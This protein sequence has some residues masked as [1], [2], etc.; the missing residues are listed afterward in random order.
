VVECGPLDEWQRRPDEVSARRHA[1]R[2]TSTAF[3]EAGPT[4]QRVAEVLATGLANLI[5]GGCVIRGRKEQ[6]GGPSLACAHALAGSLEALCR[7]FETSPYALA[8]ACCAQAT[9]TRR[10]ILIPVVSSRVMRLWTQ[11]SGWQYLDECQMGSLL[12]APVCSSHAVRATILVWR[13]QPCRPLTDTHTALLDH[14]ARRLGASSQATRCAALADPT[15][16]PLLLGP[17]Q[18]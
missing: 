15:C 7:T 13:E 2:E 11:P 4:G 1:L 6:P 3:L 12:V 8:S 9:Q 10:P 18:H 5:G 17:S 16:H 14:I